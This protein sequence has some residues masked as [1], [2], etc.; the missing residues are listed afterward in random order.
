MPLD[1]DDEWLSELFG[2][3]IS[4]SPPQAGMWHHDSCDVAIRLSSTT[5]VM[6][7]PFSDPPMWR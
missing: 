1:S 5:L 2:F 6:F 3:E 4:S 7:N